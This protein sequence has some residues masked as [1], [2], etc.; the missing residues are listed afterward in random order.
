MSD[1]TTFK[2][3]RSTFLSSKLSSRP[4]IFSRTKIGGPH[5]GSEKDPKRGPEGDQHEG[6]DRV[7][8]LKKWKF[9]VTK[10]NK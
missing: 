4:T 2:D 7:V 8:H 10:E 5:W 9:E 1:I 6:Q 3:L